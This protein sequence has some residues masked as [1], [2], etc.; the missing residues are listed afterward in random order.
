[1]ILNAIFFPG[2][3]IKEI[4]SRR[5]L[6]NCLR[7]WRIPKSNDARKCMIGFRIFRTV[8]RGLIHVLSRL[9]SYKNHET[10][11]RMHKKCTADSTFIVIEM[12][13]F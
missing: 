4:D 5:S 13:F 8:I 1:M 12:N 10:T 6:N 9:S 2:A 11:M 7:T 3:N